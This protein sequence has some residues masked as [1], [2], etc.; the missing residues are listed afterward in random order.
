MLTV[1]FGETQF[2][3]NQFRLHTRPGRDHQ[4][5]LHGPPAVH[6]K[7]GLPDTPLLTRQGCWKILTLSCHRIAN[8]LLLT[9]E[10]P[11]PCRLFQS[12]SEGWS[13]YIGFV[14]VWDFLPVWFLHD[15]PWTGSSEPLEPFMMPLATLWLFP[16]ENLLEHKFWKGVLNC[17]VKH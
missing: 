3:G 1:H 12:K 7:S 16:S 17:W 8:R 13:V 15:A 14:W 5:D 4:Q 6:Q 10:M 9:P 11:G 2:R